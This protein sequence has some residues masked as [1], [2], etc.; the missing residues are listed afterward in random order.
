MKQML[1]LT[2][3]VSACLTA[4]GCAS[5]QSVKYVPAPPPQLLDPDLSVL[6]VCLGP[7]RLPEGAVRQ[8]DVERLWITDRKAL[9]EC[10]ER[11]KALRDYYQVRDQ[12]IREGHDL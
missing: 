5:T 3:I 10:G 2:A 7:T 6:K 9:I 8:R 4:A 12:A 11:H 1:I